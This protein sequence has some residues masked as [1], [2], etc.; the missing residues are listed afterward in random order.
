MRPSGCVVGPAMHKEVTDAVSSGYRHTRK[1]M[2]TRVRRAQR[3]A[4][5][6]VVV[7]HRRHHV[8]TASGGVR[9]RA[10]SLTVEEDNSARDHNR[11]QRI[12]KQRRVVEENADEVADARKG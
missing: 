12:Q 7:G 5:A 11:I 10:L 1:R 9:G 8:P 4:G 2:R 6:Y 3:A